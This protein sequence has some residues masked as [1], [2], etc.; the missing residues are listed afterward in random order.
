MKTAIIGAS[1]AGLYLAI[2]LKKNHP[3]YEVV[4]FDKNEKIGKKIYAT[5][6]GRCNL[7][8]T[9]TSPKDY[10]HP[11]YMEPLL[12][13]YDYPRLKAELNGLG[14]EVVSEGVN[15]YPASLQASSFVKYLTDLALKLGVE[16]RLSTKIVGYHHAK[17]W[18]L[19]TD[20]GASSFDK[21]VF[22]TG[23]KSQP[24]LGSDGSLFPVFSAHGYRLVPLKP[25]LCPIVTLEKTKSLSGL[26]HEAHLSVHV[27]VS[28]IHEEA[29]ELLFKDDGLSGIV[30]F[31]CEAAIARLPSPKNVI[32]FVDLFPSLSEEELLLRLERDHLL[33]PSFFLDA[34]FV[35]AL[36]D[37]VLKEAGLVEKNG[38]LKKTDL[39]PLVK[40]MKNLVFHYSRAYPF[41]NSQVTSGGIAL[42]DVDASFC[43]KS[44]KGIAFAGECLDI[45]GLCG[46]HNLTWCLISALIISEVL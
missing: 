19:E 1:S 18:I 14:I 11:S 24:K 43:S 17:N 13:T 39:I 34:F 21:I 15:V 16:F 38:S 33:N 44:E 36:R 29:G 20:Q 6:N 12:K 30:A 22:A 25:S 40:T 2:F 8:N 41:E 9:A 35:P 3:E 46:G 37:Y 45:D 10:N 27:D 23:G 42:S 28:I 26:R 4:V 31:N 7:L 32:L 5:G